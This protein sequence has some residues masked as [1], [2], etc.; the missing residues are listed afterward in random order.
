[1]FCIKLGTVDKID[2]A[3]TEWIYRPYM[4]TTHKRQFLAVDDPEEQT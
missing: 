2:A 1:M 4:N 3:E